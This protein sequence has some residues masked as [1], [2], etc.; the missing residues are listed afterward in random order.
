MNLTA[1]KMRYY[2][3]VVQISLLISVYA[4]DV[5]PQLST[6]KMLCSKLIT[7]LGHDKLLLVSEHLYNMRKHEDKAERKGE[8]PDFIKNLFIK[9]PANKL[10]FL[11][12]FFWIPREDVLIKPNLVDHGILSSRTEGV[13]VPMYEGLAGF[14]YPD[15]TSATLSVKII[16][17]EKANPG[18]VIADNLHT[19]MT[20]DLKIKDPNNKFT[21]QS[22]REW[23]QYK[24]NHSQM[25]HVIDTQGYLMQGSTQFFEI[26]SKKTPEGITTYSIHIQ[27]LS[28]GNAHALWLVENLQRDLAPESYKKTTEELRALGVL[29]EK[30]F[31]D[32]R[33]VSI[34]WSMIGEDNTTPAEREAAAD[35]DNDRPQRDKKK[36][37]NKP[38]RKLTRDQEIMLQLLEEEERW[39]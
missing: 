14:V 18:G 8:M 17:R 16:D 1:K 37:K 23:I 15:N 5:I 25:G 36:K 32:S 38:D 39:K 28:P 27:K 30:I 4:D 2:L 24:L 20:I 10:A 6:G 3:I 31:E 9:V 22:L 33:P 11:N 21:E 12:K 7:S 13:K 26:K 34:D 29:P 19:S 35:L